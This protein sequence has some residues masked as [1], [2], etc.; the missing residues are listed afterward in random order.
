M[1]SK[2][3]SLLATEG[4]SED[5][6]LLQDLDMAALGSSSEQYAE[7]KLKLRQEYSF[8]SDDSY[9]ALRRKV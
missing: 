8:L 6:E 2:V 7:L 9:K 1:I 3:E 4:S 5:R